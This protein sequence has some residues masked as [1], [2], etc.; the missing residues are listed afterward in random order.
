MICQASSEYCNL[1]MSSFEKWDVE[2]DMKHEMEVTNTAVSCQELRGIDEV[3]NTAV[4]SRY[5]SK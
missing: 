5:K 2:R 1:E 3:S 4:H